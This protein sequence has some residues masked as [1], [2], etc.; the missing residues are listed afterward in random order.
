M[1]RQFNIGVDE[2]FHCSLKYVCVSEPMSTILSFLMAA[3]YDYKLRTLYEISDPIYA[4]VMGLSFK[5]K[6]GG[7]CQGMV[8]SQ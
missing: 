4:Q 2:D 5:K 7:G 3:T 8:S 1:E 6:G